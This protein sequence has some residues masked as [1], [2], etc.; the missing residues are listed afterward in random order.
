MALDDGEAAAKLTPRDSVPLKFWRIRLNPL[1]QLQFPDGFSQSADLLGDG[2][3]HLKLVSC[4]LLSQ[5]HEL[6]GFSTA[7]RK[8]IKQQAVSAVTDFQALGKRARLRKPH[9]EI[10][11]SACL[12]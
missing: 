11:Q 8:A 10:A 1:Q 12:E 3:E 2:H 4:V 6:F 9:G 5:L 7:A